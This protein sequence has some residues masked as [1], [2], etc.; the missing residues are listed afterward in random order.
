MEKY[1]NEKLYHDYLDFPQKWNETD[2]GIWNAKTVYCRNDKVDDYHSVA[3]VRYLVFYPNAVIDFTADKDNL[4]QKDIKLICDKLHQ[5]ISAI[6]ASG[7][8]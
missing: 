1:E 6:P 7:D 2:A 4:S 8:K 5:E 3:D